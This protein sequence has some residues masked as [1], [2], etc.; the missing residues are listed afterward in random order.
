MPWET[1]MIEINFTNFLDDI[2]GDLIVNFAKHMR[3]PGDDQAATT[4]NFYRFI[5][6]WAKDAPAHHGHV[7]CD[8]P[9]S[10]EAMLCRI[11]SGVVSE[12][13]RMPGIQED[14]LYRGVAMIAGDMADAIVAIAKADKE[15]QANIGL[16]AQVSPQK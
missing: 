1:T 10:P 12:F 11:I 15:K 3:P 16:Q 8:P 7:L 2:I 9:N 4:E 5:G 13:A 14:Q 6:D